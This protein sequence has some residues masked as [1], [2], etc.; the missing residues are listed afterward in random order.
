VR[1]DFCASY[2]NLFR[3]TLLERQRDELSRVAERIA[4]HC[5][6]EMAEAFRCLLPA[7]EA[8][9]GG[10]AEVPWQA[11]DCA[12]IL[13]EPDLLTHAV[14]LRSGQLEL[15]LA[16]EERV[17]EQ[18]AEVAAGRPR[19]A[20]NL[21]S[22]Q[23]LLEGQRLV[24]EG[25]PAEAVPKLREVDADSTWWGAAGGGVLKL[26]GRGLL[27]EALAA[28][29]DAAGAEAARA[30]LRAVNPAFERDYERFP[31]APERPPA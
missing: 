20:K 18:T 30:R 25:R 15:A 24:H 22:L 31:A 1:P 3:L 13:A 17:A 29:G 16:M 12:E 11:D 21:R 7:A 10:D 4:E 19:Y 6:P 28:S 2:E 26:V 8:F 27:A 23:M 9:L 5:E 14:A